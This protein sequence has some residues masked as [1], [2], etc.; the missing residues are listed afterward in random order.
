V[1]VSGQLRRALRCALDAKMLKWFT[2][3]ESK[4]ILFFV[5]AFSRIYANLYLFQPGRRP[6]APSTGS[7]LR[8]WPPGTNS[9]TVRAVFFCAVEI[10]RPALQSQGEPH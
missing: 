8:H 6:K 2:S 4:N 9:S 1:T 5:F 10:D 3:K 7:K